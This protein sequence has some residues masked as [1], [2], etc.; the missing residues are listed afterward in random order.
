MVAYLANFYWNSWT[1]LG[2]RRSTRDFW[3]WIK[4]RLADLCKSGI[5]ITTHKSWIQF[6][7]WWPE[8]FAGRS[9]SNTGFA[10]TNCKNCC[11][12]QSE[13]GILTSS[14]SKM[15]WKIIMALLNQM[16]HGF[17]VEGYG[18]EYNTLFQV[19]P[20]WNNQYVTF[21]LITQSS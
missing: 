17:L 18:I 5:G 6:K 11:R 16:G 15:K 1:S 8:Y 2:Q 7:W 14:L 21:K 4:I 20:R 19:R 12:M 3:R 10:T 9:R 13:A